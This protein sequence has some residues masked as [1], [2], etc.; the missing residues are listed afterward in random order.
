M[1]RLIFGTLG[2]L[3]IFSEIFQLVSPTAKFLKPIGDHGVK[4]L[5]KINSGKVVSPLDYDIV[6]LYCLLIVVIIVRK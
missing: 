1:L 5:Q 6:K 4:L 3:V 2:S